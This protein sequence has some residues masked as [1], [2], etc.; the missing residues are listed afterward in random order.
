MAVA[1][2]ASALEMVFSF[3]EEGKVRCHRGGLWKC[4]VVHAFSAFKDFGTDLRE[5]IQ[6]K[7]PRC[8]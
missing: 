7:L 2:T 3:G 6:E 1:F 5:I 8:W 4:A